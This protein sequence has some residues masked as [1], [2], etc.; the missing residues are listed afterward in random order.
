L[1]SK[2]C[3]SRRVSLPFR[4][5]KM[6]NIFSEKDDLRFWSRV[7]KQFLGC[8]I[9]SGVKTKGGYGVF[10]IKKQHTYAHRNSYRIFKG[11]IPEGLHIDHLCRARNCVNPDHLEL[12]TPIENTMRGNSSQAINAR[13]THCKNG[14]EFS[15]YNLL[16][17]SN[18]SR[19]CRKCRNDYKSLKA[20]EKT[21]L[22]SKKERTHCKQG[23]I[24]SEDNLAAFQLKQGWKYCRTCL[25]EKQNV[26]RKIRLERKYH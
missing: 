8:W 10:Y 24:L 7:E 5:G 12:V 2:C 22:K 20:R 6:N 18:G 9:W 14:H 17:R 13:K 1:Q 11:D 19:I 15:G 26:R 4:L 3:C 16:F 25:N 23:H 21:K